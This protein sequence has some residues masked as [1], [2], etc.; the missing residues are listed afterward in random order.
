MNRRCFLQATC[1]ATVSVIAP[2]F[3]DQKRLEIIKA[4]IEDTGNL[5]ILLSTLA[6]IA[7][8]P[9][10]RNIGVAL[11]IVSEFLE[12]KVVVEYIAGTVDTLYEKIS[13]KGLKKGEV[14][15]TTTKVQEEGKVI[16]YPSSSSSAPPSP[17]VSQSTPIITYTKSQHV[18]IE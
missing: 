13:A 7:G 15:D 3:G 6:G 10:I 18:K 4:Y 14:I 5:S 2:A 16:E 1:V 9:K 12:I 17:P 8:I 11:K